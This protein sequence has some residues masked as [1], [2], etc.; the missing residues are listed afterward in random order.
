MLFS[1]VVD[2]DFLE[3]ERF[4]ASAANSPI[5]R[6]GRNDLTAL[7]D[8][9]LDHTAR[10]RAKAT[11]APVNRMLSEALDHAAVGP[12]RRRTTPIR[13]VCMSHRG[14]EPPYPAETEMPPSTCRTSPVMNDASCESRNPMAFATS[15]SLHNRP[16]GVFALRAS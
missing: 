16:S 14:G 11:P 1:C 7:R 10:A 15:R 8:R 12:G 9:L 2:A 6:G 4:L 3:T 5:A 13:S